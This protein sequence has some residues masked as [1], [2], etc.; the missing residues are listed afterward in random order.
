M[1]RAR[2]II[3]GRTYLV[4]RR[5]FRR[6]LLLR[7][8]PLINRIIGY[9][10]AVASAR[11]GVLIHAVCALANHY[12]LV[13]SDPRGEL[14]EFMRWLNEF[15]A[16]CIN[17]HFGRWESVWAPG[18]Y[19]AVHAVEQNDV[20]AK[21]VYTLHN[22]VG[23]LLVRYGEEWPGLRSRPEDM[24]GQTWTFKR[25][26]V[27]FS[28]KSA[29]P[30]E[31]TLTFCPPPDVEDVEAFVRDVASVLAVVDESIR[32][33]VDAS[34]KR[35]LGR[36]AILA[37]RHT[38]FPRTREPRRNLNPRVACRDKWRRIETLQR[39]KEFHRSYQEAYEAFRAGLPDVL[40]PLGTY[41]MR[42]YAGVRC[43]S[44]G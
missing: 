13:L 3:P 17:A 42:R 31:A 29:L 21:S 24:L 43:A 36:A 16:K 14:P 5:C 11:Y 33:A 30:E 1:S 4:T 20:V 7:P 2:P 15:I 6:Q 37:Q 39:L 35:F 26:E 12:H 23:S 28:E 10:L 40:F 8:S 38:D 18:S 25:P 9:C 27:F 19:S 34:G 44:A 22:P 32:R 41:W